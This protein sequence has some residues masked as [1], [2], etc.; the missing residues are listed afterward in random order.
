MWGQAV[1]RTRWI[2]YGRRSVESN[3]AR[4]PIERMF[5]F[6]GSSL[7]RYCV[8]CENIGHFRRYLYGRRWN[9]R[10]VSLYHD[11]VAS[12]TTLPFCRAVGGS[13]SMAMANKLC[14]LHWRLCFTDRSGSIGYC[15]SL[16]VL[17][18]TTPTG[19]FV[20]DCTTG[21]NIARR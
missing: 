16:A 2:A 9:V 15:S 6:S 13:F 14:P 17:P 10:K 7:H 12:W 20:C 3:K 19:L 8:C 4:L 5:V 21:I 18:L 11:T 1:V